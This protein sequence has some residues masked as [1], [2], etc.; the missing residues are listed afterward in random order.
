MRLD[1]CCL[2]RN[3]GLEGYHVYKLLKHHSTHELRLQ[4]ESDLSDDE[5]SKLRTYVVKRCKLAA[6]A[7]YGDA[8]AEQV[9]MLHSTQC[10]QHAVLQHLITTRQTA[11]KL[12]TYGQEMHI[13]VFAK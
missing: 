10:L 4:E 9:M 5:Q 7:L 6:A 1:K 13:T 3:T 2:T 12:P 8:R 11:C